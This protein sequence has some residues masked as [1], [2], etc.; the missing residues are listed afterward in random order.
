MVAMGTRVEGLREARRQLARLGGD[1]KTTVKAA[2]K[3]AAEVVVE[4]AER[5]VP[6]RTG[7]LKGS[8]RA[9]AS[10]ASARAVAG[11]AAVPYAA[12]IHWGRIKGGRIN[13]RPYLWNAAA[14]ANDEVVVIYERAVAEAVRKGQR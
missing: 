4:Y 6:V 5:R 9:L 8:L 11:S 2:N 13:G 12:V 7:R 1:A 3:D 10:G 14:E